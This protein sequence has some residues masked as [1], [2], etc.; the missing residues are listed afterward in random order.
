[1]KAETIHKLEKATDIASVAIAGA[2]FAI[3]LA[4][5]IANKDTELL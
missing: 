1:M 2:I 4:E 3:K 5:L